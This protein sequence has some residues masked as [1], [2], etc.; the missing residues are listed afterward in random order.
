MDAVKAKEELKKTVRDC[1]GYGQEYTDEEVSG[2]I[3]DCIMDS[4]GLR[5]LPV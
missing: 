5:L 3:D 4:P 1:L 2:I